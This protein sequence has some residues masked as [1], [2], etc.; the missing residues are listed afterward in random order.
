MTGGS[1]ALWTAARPLHSRRM[2]ALNSLTEPD[3]IKERISGHLRRTPLQARSSEKPSFARRTNL[4][5]NT[6]SM[7]QMA[8]LGYGAIALGAT[9]EDPAVDAH[10]R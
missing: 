9:H 3:T 4:R 6:D 1:Q 2:D 8:H 10:V 5:Q 7:L